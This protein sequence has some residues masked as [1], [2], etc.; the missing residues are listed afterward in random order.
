MRVI[1]AEEV[2]YP[3]V[4]LPVQ[5]EDE[6]GQWRSEGRR[7]RPARDAGLALEGRKARDARRRAKRQRRQATSVAVAIALLGVLALGWQYASDKRAQKEPLPAAS[8]AE[9]PTGTPSLSRADAP[10]PAI[11]GIRAMDPANDPTPIFARL[12]SLEVH[13]PVRVTDLT[14]VGFH[15]ASY[16]YALH[17]TTPLP[18]ADT[19]KVKR[20]R[21][22]HRDKASQPTGADAVLVGSVLRMWRSRPGKPD[23]AADVGAAPG[24]DVF[25]PITGTIVKI[26]RFKL[27]GKYDDYEIHIQPTGRANIDCVMIHVDD[28][29]CKVGDRVTGGVTRI[30]AVRDLDKRVNPQLKEF[31]RNG[32]YHTHMQL[33][34]AD[35]PQYKGLKG[36]ISVD[37]S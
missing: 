34:N 18:T 23:S 22:T 7:L 15:Q 16:T 2:R 21:T 27:Y 14:E 9:N 4:E 33:N 25:S 35:D 13:L 30:A 24:S 8:T 37:G 19:D 31:T 3:G 11:A 29:S 12:G 28:L 36:A 1:R 5:S 10:D 26:K 20:E 6:Y 17:M 32:G